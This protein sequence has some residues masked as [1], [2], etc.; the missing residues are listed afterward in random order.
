MP[1]ALGLLAWFA[2]IR[3]LWGDWRIDPQYSYGMVVPL[4]TAGLVLKRMQDRPVSVRPRARGRLVAASALIG[5]ALL[6]GMTIPL[7]EANPDWRPVGLLASL[8]AVSISLGSLYLKGGVAWLRHFALPV[9]FFLIAVPWPRNFEQSVMGG[10]M[11]WNASATLEILHWLGYEAMRQGNLIVIPSGVLGVEE[12]CSGVRSLQSGI[13]VS[14]FFGEILRLGIRRRVAL[15]AMAVFAALAGNIVRS[16][17]LAVIG[18]RQGIASVSS[19][20]DTAGMLVLAFTF[21]T[22]MILAY[23]WK[24]PPVD[25]GTGLHLS[26]D[27][28]Q[29]RGSVTMFM[30]ASLFLIMALGGTEFWYRLHETEVPGV[31]KWSLQPMGEHRG[32]TRVMIPTETMKMLFYPEGFSERWLIGD[33]AGGQ[34]FYFRWPAGRTSLQASAMHRPEV[35]LANLGMKLIRSLPEHVHESN[36]VAIPF[37]AWL[38]DQKGVPVYVFQALIEESRTQ[39]SDPRQLDESSRGRFRAVLA[40]RRNRG[41]RMIEVA[42]C[43]LPDERTAGEA[44][45]R[46]L[47]NALTVELIAAPMRR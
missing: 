40:G 29:V 33:H 14:L 46:Y 15:V 39:T 18:S 42:F 3:I 47:D 31:R 6:L 25:Q 10:L 30:G 9:C 26:P 28:R 13:M 32:A 23:R 37:R 12:A 5:S 38:F 17:L 21:G 11:S 24:K 2:V 22:V 20:H 19:W 34:S 44:L 8:M 41:Q 16:S 7:A 36:G 35:C 43:N 4:L 27:E 1:L 45:R